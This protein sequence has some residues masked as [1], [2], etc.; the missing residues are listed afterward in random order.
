MK[1]IN[2]RFW[3]TINFSFSLLTLFILNKLIG[4]NDARSSFELITNL[5]RQI[6]LFSGFNLISG[7]LLY[8]V[9]NNSRSIN[10]FRQL[11]LLNIVVV[12]ILSIIAC[13]IISFF[14]L[15]SIEIIYAII[16]LN[17]ILS[18]DYLGFLSAAIGNVYVQYYC[19]FILKIANISA[20]LL[21]GFY[22]FD[23]S[24]L[25]PTYLISLLYILYASSKINLSPIYIK[26]LRPLFIV[27]KKIVLFSLPWF[28]A[29]PILNF[30]STYVWLKLDKSDPS[31]IAYYSILLF[32]SSSLNLLL[33][34]PVVDKLTFNIRQKHSTNKY[35]LY[36]FV[37]VFVLIGLSFLLNS[38]LLVNNNYY[39]YFMEDLLFFEPLFIS[40]YIF[41]IPLLVAFSC[42]VLIITRIIH[43]KKRQKSYAAISLLVALLQL[44]LIYIY[45]DF[46]VFDFI[47]ISLL[48]SFVTYI[49]LCFYNFKVIRKH[50][51]IIF[52]FM[53]MSGF[54]LYF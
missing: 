34:N 43:I 2:N 51:I 44:L 7:N 39:K 5:S 33:V 20:I 24:I 49:I 38:T 47:N 36:F 41:Y 31:V 32:G 13:F 12:S 6:I 54:L 9:N 50:Q 48:T 11:F 21:I 14:N 25:L 35:Y 26:S 27:L 37:L 42:P 30:F 8:F 1:F 52:I 22:D 40:S 46:N 4:F 45:D 3:N 19:Q 16:I 53:Y 29:S 15:F 10:L 18:F 17:V 23:I 28:L